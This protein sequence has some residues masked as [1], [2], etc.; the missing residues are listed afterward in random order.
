MRLLSWKRRRKCGWFPTLDYI[1]R[2]CIY[3]IML[4]LGFLG[5]SSR[6]IPREGCSVYYTSI[7]PYC[8][9]GMV[10]YLM[11]LKCAVESDGEDG[12]NVLVADLLKDRA[13]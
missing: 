5:G 4:V 2:M 9:T 11:G 7:P 3:H 13:A 10:P 8:L 6:L 12:M 1:M